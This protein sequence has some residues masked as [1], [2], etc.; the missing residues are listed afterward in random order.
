MSVEETEHVQNLNRI[1]TEWD[2]DGYSKQ[3][4]IH[5][6][7]AIEFGKKVLKIDEWTEKTLVRGLALDTTRPVPDYFERNNMSARKNMGV[8]R[9]KFKNWEQNG[10]V[11]EVKEP[12]RIIN[13]LSLVSKYDGGAD[14]MKHRPVID[15]SRHVNLLVED[16]KVK[17]NDLAYFE[18][19]FERNAYGVTWD[20]TSMYHQLKLTKGTAE[21][22]GCAVEQEDGSVKFYK[23]QCL[24]FGQKA[25]VHIMTWIL[26]P[27]MNFLRDQSIKAGIFIDDGMALNTN[28]KV[29]E[30][31][32]KFIIKLF[33]NSGW[34]LNLEKSSLVPSQVVMYQGF[35]LDFKEM[36]YFLAKWK[37]VMI[38]QRITELLVASSD[39]REVTAKDIE[40]VVGKSIAC[41]KSHGPAMMIGL[42]HIQHE[43]GK[44]VMH[45]GPEYEPDWTVSLTLDEQSRVELKYVRDILKEEDGYPFPVQGEAKV[46]MLNEIEYSTDEAYGI[47]DKHYR[48][49]ASDAS[50]K[51][52][53]VYEAGE[54]K[55]VE[56]YAFTREEQETSS[57]QRELL[58]IQKTLKNRRRE[59]E[60]QKG[61][62]YWITDSQNVHSFMKRGSRKPQ[63]QKMVLDI[64]VMEKEMGI[65][66]ITIWKPRS[67]KHIVWADLGSKA[68]LSTD[69]WSIDNRTFKQ[70]QQHIGL[71]V[72]VDGF[73]TS[74]NRR[75]DRF[76][77]KYPQC[78]SEGIDFFAQKLSSKEVYWLC[79]PVQLVLTTI[80]HILA[81]ENQV[82]AYVSFPE[83]K[84]ANFW[85]VV[86]QGARYA[87]FVRAVFVS[88]PK[89]T[90]HNENS[91]LFNG[92]ESF[93]FLTILINNKFIQNSVSRY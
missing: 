28:S 6:S 34:D 82:I 55:L 17:L 25:A 92:K 16:K 51:V 50:E 78:G 18:P 26:K 36:R 53:F 80:K 70:I 33:E 93:R 22:F 65:R 41:R 84:S 48:V 7:K 69:E 40:S 32:I 56:E 91:R 2:N 72:T 52:A 66:I 76:F 13:P 20:F 90:A 88:N 1:M 4:S 19:L 31:E 8:L 81:I 27:A 83:W 47:N 11:I 63:I 62:V 54:F 89:Y 3:S 73:A 44:K 24:M 60:S 14:K 30:V 38:R 5:D 45:R 21:L 42:R 57:G 79:P 87:P 59:M 37:S 49:F 23:F 64:K 58:A 85:P 86:K 43:V 35:Y 39:N 46:F 61:R 12:P 71:E 9:E 10:K 29:L 77:S 75:V 68:Y 15:M 67:T 74:A